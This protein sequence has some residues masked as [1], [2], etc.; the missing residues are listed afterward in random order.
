[1]RN[2][3][4]KYIWK[5]TATP[6]FWGTVIG[7]IALYFSCYLLAGLLLVAIGYGGCG[8]ALSIGVTK[9]RDPWRCDTVV[10]A[11]IN[12]IRYHRDGCLWGLISHLPQAVIGT[13]IL[14]EAC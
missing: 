1:M 9:D 3:L 4:K 7:A 12:A 5:V 13:I 10:E 11:V 14:V 6:S 8:I 2:F